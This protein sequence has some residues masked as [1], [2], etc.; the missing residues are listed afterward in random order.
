MWTK[1]PSAEYSQQHTHT[2]THTHTLTASVCSQPVN[3]V[4]SPILI[5]FSLD[6]DVCC[7]SSLRV[8]SATLTC[9]PSL[10]LTH[11]H[12]HTH[13][14]ICTICQLRD[15]EFQGLCSEGAYRVTSLYHFAQSLK[16][17]LLICQEYLPLHPLTLAERPL[18]TEEQSV[19]QRWRRL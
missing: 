10:S 12:T 8:F 5:W 18:K 9:S 19:L 6:L 2:H 3:E 16:G 4:Y 7:S 13:T 11:T 1:C 14:Q 17:S 15:S